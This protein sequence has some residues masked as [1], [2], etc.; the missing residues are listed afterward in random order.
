M[1]RFRN[2]W[3]GLKM[4][5][6]IETGGRQYRVA[7]NDVISV[8]KLEGD[9]GD[10]LVLEKVLL[11]NDQGHVSIGQPYLKGLAVKATIIDQYRDQKIRIFK[12]KRRKRY[13]K[14][15]GHRQYLTKIR[16]DDILAQ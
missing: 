9:Q 10:Q 5:A 3:E 13:Q 12:M 11:F 7:K 2:D 14:T 4:F 6:I 1:L 15:T 8:E 16:V